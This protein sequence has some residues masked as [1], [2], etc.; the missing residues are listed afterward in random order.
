M[1]IFSY[2]TR[3]PPPIYVTEADFEILSNLAE[4]TRAPGGQVL[5]GEMA[6]AVI[7]EPDE[8]P[9][10]FARIGSVV[11]FEDLTGGQVRRMR[12]SLPRD[13]SLEDNRISVVAP[14]GAALIGMIAGET[15]EWIDADGRTRGVRLLAIEA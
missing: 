2:P 5:A 13:A 8:A 15:F 7:V 14:V 3:T 6:R 9:A 10:P 11:E 1:T 12:L 4:A